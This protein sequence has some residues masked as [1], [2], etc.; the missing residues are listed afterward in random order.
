MDHN[1]FNGNDE[2]EHGHNEIE[3]DNLNENANVNDGF[4][5]D[6]EMVEPIQAREGSTRLE[7]EMRWIHTYYNTTLPNENDAADLAL[8][9]ATTS[10]Y[11]EPEHFSEAWDHPNLDSRSKWIIIIVKK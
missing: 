2:M 9:S 10:G 8:V 7:R 5:D 6:D 4:S 3:H 11:M 1:N